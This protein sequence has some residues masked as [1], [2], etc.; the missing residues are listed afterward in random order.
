MPI[1]IDVLLPTYNPNPQ[2]LKEAIECVLKQTYPHFQLFI[3]DDASPRVDTEAIVRPYLSDPRI[4]F[5]RSTKNLGIGGNWNACLKQTKNPIV[6]YMFQDDLW[7]PEYLQTAVQVFEERLDVGL[8]AIEHEY[9]MEGVCASSSMY[10]EIVTMKHSVLTQQYYVGTEFLSLWLE[11]GLHP[12]F[13]GEPSFVMLRRSL[14]ENVGTFLED[15]PQNLDS[16]YWIRCLLQTNWYYVRRSLGAF[17]V[18]SAGTSA[19]NQRDGK[20]LFDRFRCFENLIALLPPGGV[21]VIALRA[22]RKAL[23]GMIEKFFMRLQSQASVKVGG[24]GSRLIAF[25]CKHPLLIIQSLL[26]CG[27]RKWI[28]KNI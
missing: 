26:R 22:Q 8:V 14:M 23:D 6:Q 7:E 11:M 17:R 20:G 9:R 18:H 25:A 4:R 24:N 1:T 15:M 21:K 13:I 19:V 10:Q 3:H 12:N 27:Y 16:E 5:Q 2:Y 28:K